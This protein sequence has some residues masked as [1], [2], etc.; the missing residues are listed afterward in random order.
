VNELLDDL[1][2]IGEL[3]HVDGARH[4]RVNVVQWQIILW[5]GVNVLHEEAQDLLRLRL[6]QINVSR[7]R[8]RFII[9]DKIFKCSVFVCI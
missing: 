1:D 8:K 7:I 2:Q 5:Y 4:L 6:V 9:G 3:V